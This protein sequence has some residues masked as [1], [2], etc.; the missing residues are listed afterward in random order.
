MKVEEIYFTTNSHQA[1]FRATVP[2]SPSQAAS[3]VVANRLVCAPSPALLSA[4]ARLLL[5][6]GLCASP[7]PCAARAPLMLISK[8]IY[9][10]ALSVRFAAE[11]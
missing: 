7:L 9:D 8:V 1:C 5:S 11:Q 6:G 10:C 2:C 3:Y 4:C